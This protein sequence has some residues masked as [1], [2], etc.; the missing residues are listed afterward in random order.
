MTLTLHFSI[1]PMTF[2]S[3]YPTNRMGRRFLTP[4]GKAYKDGIRL[5]T[6]RQNNGIFKVDPNRHWVRAEYLFIMPN[7][8]VKSGARING[9]KQDEDGCVKLLQD[10]ICEALKFDDCLITES[11]RRQLAG[12]T[13][14]VFV[15]YSIGEISSLNALSDAIRP[16]ISVPA[17][18]LQ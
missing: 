6:L 9:R 18:T 10:A 5:N 1:A 17:S 7:L 13:S 11:H 3:A 12:K 2:N 8:L 4:E 14:E 15:R 16:F